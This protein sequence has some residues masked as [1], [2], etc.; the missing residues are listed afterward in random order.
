MRYVV[1]RERNGAASIRHV[2][3]RV[4]WSH[5]TVRDV[6]PDGDIFFVFVIFLLFCLG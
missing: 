4:F 6:L 3:S 2:S 5:E 1:A